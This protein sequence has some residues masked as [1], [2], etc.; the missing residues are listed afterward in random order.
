MRMADS[1][2]AFDDRKGSL[3][4]ELEFPKKIGRIGAGVQSESVRACVEPAIAGGI[5][6]RGNE[7][8]FGTLECIEEGEAIDEGE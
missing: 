6:A 5:V 4:R 8:Q 1:S 7:Y 3:F 2:E